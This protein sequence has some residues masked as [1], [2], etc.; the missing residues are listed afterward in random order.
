MAKLI[1]MAWRNV[2]RNWRRTAIALIAIVLGLILLLL[3]NGFITGSDQAIFGNAVRLYGGNIQ[4]HAPG[5]RAKASRLPLLPLPNA[6]AV[7]EAVRSNPQVMAATKRI[8]TPGLISSREGAFPVAITG[9][10]PVVESAISIQAENISAGRYLQDGDEDVIVIGRGLA[11]LLK[12]N[13]DD[14]VTLVGRRKNET[15]RQRTM[16]IVGIYDLGMRD[17]EKSAVFMSLAEAQ[18]LYNMRDSASEVAVTLQSV[19]QEDT[20]IAELQA[21]LPG[22]EVD[23]WQTL[24]PEIA[25]T[26]QTKAAFTSFFGF[27]VLLIASIGILN[28]MLMAVFERTREMG[29]L[30][31]L[32]MKRRQ[33]L[34]LFLL[35]GAFIG[36]VGAVLGCI[37]GALVILALDQV[38][39]DLSFAQ[40]MGEITALMGS[41]LYPAVTLNQII[42]RGIGVVIIAALAALYPAWQ[43]ARKEPADALHHV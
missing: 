41:R 38:G 43:A 29:V 4:I 26:I 3:L 12:V 27:I 13:V 5:Y 24:R 2:W 25:Q 33:I 16:T 34:T 40:G 7:V 14:R 31:A 23:S 11:D 8:N 39:L 35:E 6:D 19:G 15:M 21:L 17:A 37:L 36:L 42:S 30:A 22:Y 10:E 32:G 28:L 20:V 1:T 9:L 18:S